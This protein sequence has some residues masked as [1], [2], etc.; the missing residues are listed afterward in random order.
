[1]FLFTHGLL[2]ACFGVQV[3]ARGVLRAPASVRRPLTVAMEAQQLLQAQHQAQA[4]R[5]GT[6]RMNNLIFLIADKK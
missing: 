1:M 2:C 5:W 6:S 4:A 3:T